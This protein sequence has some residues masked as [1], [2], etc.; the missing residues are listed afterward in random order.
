MNRSTTDQSRV[1]GGV[2]AGGQFATETRSEADVSLLSPAPADSLPSLEESLAALTKQWEQRSWSPDAAAAQAQQDVEQAQSLA[3]DG[4]PAQYLAA[5]LVA[6]GATRLPRTY[7]R[8]G[9]FGP[10]GWRC[11]QGGEAMREAYASGMPADWPDQMA[12][13]GEAW[14]DGCVPRWNAG[15]TAEE[16]KRLAFF[17][18]DGQPGVAAAYAGKDL[19]EVREWINAATADKG[20]SA[21]LGR[22]LG[23][24][25]VGAYID[26]AVALE[27][28][29]LAYTHDLE[30][31]V[32]RT[33]L[34]RPDGSV[35][36][37]P[38]AIVE[39]AQYKAACGMSEDHAREG[40]RAGVEAKTMKAFGPKVTAP[41]INELQSAGVPAKVARSLR[42]KDQQMSVETIA[43]CHE[44]G[45]TS[46]AD[47]KGWLAVTEE[48]SSGGLGGRRNTTSDLPAALA[49]SKA[50][51]PL[52][53]AQSLKSQGIPAGAIGAMHAGGVT[54][55]S[56]W[57]TGVH[58]RTQVTAKGQGQVP[59]LT[60]V[61]DFARAGGT[62]EQFARAQRA[63]VPLSDLGSHVTSSPAALWD[64]GAANRA[65]VL[66]EEKRVHDQWGPQFASE[67]TPWP[68][69]GPDDL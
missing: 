46:G 64:A 54:D 37:G 27:D 9:A 19:L 3:G 68:V 28:V 61:A 66:A 16:L 22:H 20:F 33:G 6:D 12:D 59:A 47:Y 57:R 5:L 18:M 49:L 60:H 11:P 14:R 29:Q 13:R 30:P 50:G 43:Q 10:S 35:E 38:D 7:D 41:E 25:G 56:P 34:T 15:V 44:A 67:P 62:P 8:G 2:P 1:H 42:G 23:H 24:A 58:G 36:Q 45:I 48:T 17:G 31:G 51:V 63:G 55:W 53:A 21:Y 69:T 26:E 4:V 40:I 52:A 65:A 39:I 32:A